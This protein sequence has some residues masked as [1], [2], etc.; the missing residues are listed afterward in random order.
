MHKLTELGPHHTE[1]VNLIIHF[2]D[3]TI[4]VLGNCGIYKTVVLVVPSGLMPI[5]APCSPV[6]MTSQWCPLCYPEP[7]HLLYAFGCSSLSQVRTASSSSGL[8][9]IIDRVEHAGLH[10]NTSVMLTACGKKSL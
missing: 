2:E 5:G 3:C 1:G 10:S 7:H 6:H 9:A 8:L 4:T